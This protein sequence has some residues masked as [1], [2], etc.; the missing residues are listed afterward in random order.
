M[1]LLDCWLEDGMELQ[2]YAHQEL[3]E[4]LINEM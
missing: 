3:F 1:F 4:A 2:N